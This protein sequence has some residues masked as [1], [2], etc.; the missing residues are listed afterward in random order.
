LLVV[1]EILEFPEAAIHKALSKLSWKLLKKEMDKFPWYKNPIEFLELIMRSDSL[2]NKR[3]NAEKAKKRA[4]LF[5]ELLNHAATKANDEVVGQFKKRLG[6]FAV[7]DECFNEVLKFEGQLSALKDLSADSRIWAAMNWFV[8]DSRILHKKIED[9]FKSGKPVLINSLSVTGASGVPVD[10]SIYHSQQVDAL[11]SAI[12]MEAYRCSWFD[13]EGV[14]EIPDRVHV[15]DDETFKAGSILYNANIWALI[16][17]LQ[18]QVRFLG[19]EFLVRASEEYDNAPAEFKF[20]IEFGNN[21]GAE[22]FDYIAGQRNATRES[23]N[24]FSI[25]K[26]V[27]LNSLLD[28]VS[29][30]TGSQTIKDHHIASSSLSVLLS[31]NVL[32]DETLYEGLSIADWIDGF[33]GLREFCSSRLSS[34]VGINRLMSE[35]I[36]FSK[37]S[38]SEHLQSVGMTKEK[39]VAFI[40]K[41]TF[42]RKARDLFD[43]PLIKTSSGY[44]VVSDVLL[45]SVISRAVASNILSRKGEFKPKGEGLESAL[46]EIFTSNGIEAVSYKK[47]FPDPEGEYEYD[48]LILWDGK[49]FVMECKNRW[50]CEGRSVAIYNFLRQTRADINQVSRL[51]NGLKLHPEMVNA[52]FGRVVSYDEIIPCVVGGMPHAMPDQVSGIYFTDISIISRFFSDR[53][54]GIEYTDG[55]RKEQNIFYDQWRSSKPSVSDFIRVLARPVQVEIVKG[56]INIKAVEHPVGTSIYLKSKSISSK[57]LDQDAYKELLSRL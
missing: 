15:G 44:V 4:E 16:D 17:N 34:S 13:S 22:V 29:S 20:G 33:C 42:H 48:A 10:P 7:A 54:F 1:N 23:S 11:G 41:A 39:S 49:L 53:Y 9:V 51:V 45:G 2:L 50:L 46:K 19:R 28:A 27:K 14:V 35:L 52:A 12:L 36:T 26:D 38:L 6:F 55:D 57:Y 40:D 56:S 18:E 43:A 3:A 30:I 5:A 25:K 37:E 8:A 24:F 47:K 21:T 32:E 31:Y